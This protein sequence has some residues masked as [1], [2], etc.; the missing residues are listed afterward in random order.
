LKPNLLKSSDFKKEIT[1]NILPFW[2]NHSPDPINGGFYGALTNDLQVH[3]EIP[4]S[5]I[6]VARI[7][8]SFAAAYRKFGVTSY[9]DSAQYAYDYLMGT[10]RDPLYEGI[11]WNVDLHGQ[12]V[13]NRK[14]HYAQA[15]AIYSLSEYYQASGSEESLGYAQKLFALLEIHAYD[16]VN[17]GYIE[18]SSRE[19]STLEDMR[20]S[21][22]DMNCRKSMN[23]LLHM[24]EAYTGLA[25]VWSEPQVITQLARLLEVFLTH[26]IHPETG[27]LQLFFDDQWHSLS[28]TISFGHDIEC[29]WLLWEAALAAGDAQLS[30]RVRQ[31]VLKMARA[32][33]ADGRDK[34]GSLFQEGDPQG[35]KPIDKEWWTQA[36]GVVGFYNAWQLTGDEIY[37]SAAEDCWTIIQ[38]KLIDRQYGD[39][40]KRIHPDGSPNLDSFKIGPWEC[41][42]H[43]TRMCLEMMKRL[44]GS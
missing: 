30:E 25:Q 24:L 5:A 40:L 8:W 41:P 32:V 39:W 28:N 15:F 43:H 20:L 12:P 18:G 13:T 4:R 17:Q 35:I 23:T 6:L 9:L 33:Y 10:F 19:W 2:M 36:E 27:H 7:L 42:Y 16:P 34:D 14:H 3:N 38:T 1:S 22:K 26:V 31:A 37:L 11:Y 21:D 44:N 29:S